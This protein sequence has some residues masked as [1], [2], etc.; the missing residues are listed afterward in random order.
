MKLGIENIETMTPEQ[1][2]DFWIVFSSDIARDDGAA[3]KKHFSVGNPVY[4]QTPETPEGLIE[5]R[6]PDGRRQ[7]VRWE[8]DGEHVVSE[9]PA[10]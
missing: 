4:C 9:A 5:K 1:E 6:F 10:S 2:R 8:R 3:V 7:F